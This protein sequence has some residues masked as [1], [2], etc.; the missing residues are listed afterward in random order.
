MGFG[1]PHAG[2]ISLKAEYKRS[3]QGGLVGASIDIHGEQAF[4]LALQ[5]REQHIRR[6]KSNQQY[7]YGPSTP[8][9]YCGD[10]WGLPWPRRLKNIAQK[11]AF[12]Y[13]RICGNT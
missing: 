5:T 11:D 6:E 4:R 7:L 10:V 3:L 1:G 12:A 13:E 2:Y 9:N 8:C